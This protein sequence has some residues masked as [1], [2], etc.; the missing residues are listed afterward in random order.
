MAGTAFATAAGAV[1]GT[2]A[3]ANAVVGADRIGAAAACAT[4][5]VAAAAMAAGTDPA[6][7][8]AHF[9]LC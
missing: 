7:S 2:D 8:L 1:C 4:L 5:A 6:M 3:G 9:W